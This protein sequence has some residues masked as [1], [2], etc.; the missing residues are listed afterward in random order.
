[1]AS[2]SSRCGLSMAGGMA[3]GGRSLTSSSVNKA[4]AATRTAVFL[5]CC[6]CNRK[7]ISE[8]EAFIPEDPTYLCG[9]SLETPLLWSRP[10]LW[11]S[12]CSRESGETRVN[13]RSPYGVSRSVG[14]SAVLS[15]SKRFLWVFLPSRFTPSAWPTI[16]IDFS[17]EAFS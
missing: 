6:S 3:L 10:V 16:A 15:A 11:A 8:R 9:C 12:N 7:K 4:S 13:N 1:M 17:M 14:G 5:A 2:R